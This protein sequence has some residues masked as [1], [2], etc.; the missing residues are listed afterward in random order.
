MDT[1]FKA[2]QPSDID[3]LLTLMQEFYQVEH[4]EFDVAIARNALTDLLNNESLGA[5]WLI[6]D[7]GEAIGY[8]VLTFGYS[9][10]F[11]GRDA[12][13][14]ELYVRANY[15]GQGIGTKT[16]EFVEEVCRSR[17]IHTL[18]LEVDRKNTKAQRFYD[19]VGFKNQGRY[20]LSKWL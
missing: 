8:I 9:L 1:T 6:Q 5:I 19:R 10:E 13:I 17:C 4:L 3:I 7:Q 2:A 12:F 15:Q 20:L 18:H 11:A 16:I 14:D